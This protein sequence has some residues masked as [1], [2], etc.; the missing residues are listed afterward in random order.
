MATPVVFACSNTDPSPPAPPSPLPA[1]TV[2]DE[3][4]V[5]PSNPITFAPPPPPPAYHPPL[6]PRFP[7][8]KVSSPPAPSK[9]AYPE[10]PPPEPPSLPRAWKSSSE[11]P[12]PPPSAT[13]LTPGPDIAEGSPLNPDAPTSVFVFDEAP[14]AP[15]KT[16]Y[17]LFAVNCTDS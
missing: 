7:C 8:P 10:A 5:P 6:P 3:L 13:T 16:P 1:V 17:F 4:R 11:P 12:P 14:P 9:L 15:T 2:P